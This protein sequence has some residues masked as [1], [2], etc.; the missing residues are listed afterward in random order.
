MRANFMLHTQVTELI[1]SVLVVVSFQFLLAPCC[2]AADEFETIFDLRENEFIL[3]DVTIPENSVLNIFGGSRVGSGAS[4]NGRSTINVFGGEVGDN[5]RSADLGS[6]VNVF[7][8][9]VGSLNIGRGAVVNIFGGNID[10]DSLSGGADRWVGNFGELNVSGGTFGGVAQI[11]S[12]STFNLT[13]TEFFLNGQSISGGAV[14]NPLIIQER[15][16]T[17]SGILLDGSPFSFFLN[18]VLEPT[19]T[20]DLFQA[21][22]IVT[23]TVVPEPDSAVICLLTGCVSLLRRKKK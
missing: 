16:V 17:L 8:G 4:T 21:D 20:Q 11:F 19:R 9:N 10:G 5:L 23:V 22:A 7:D 2:F 6:V 14:G 12:R 15:E 3:D 18:S 13:G 1:T